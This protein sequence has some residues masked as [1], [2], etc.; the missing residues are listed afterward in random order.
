MCAWLARITSGGGVAA[1]VDTD[2]AFDPR[3]AARAGVD[4]ARLLWVRCGGRCGA[5][6]RAT[7]VLVRRPGFA[8]VGLDAGERPPRLTLD[9]AFRLKLAVRRTG[10]ALVVLAPRRIA[11]PGAALVIE[12]VQDALDWS[13][14][15]A[16]ATRL[17][18]LCTRLSLVRPP[19][20]R[21]P[22]VAGVWPCTARFSA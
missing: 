13:G 10:A 15:A 20:T 4:L 22:R 2:D 3:S 12:A 16:P 14:P 1:L 9:A 17:D 18:A 7:D 21:H 8:L 6:L 11:G 5:A 19:T